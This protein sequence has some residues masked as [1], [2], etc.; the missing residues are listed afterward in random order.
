ML[1]NLFV[2]QTV[3]AIAEALTSL[4]V[5]AGAGRIAVIGPSRVCR[6]LAE[7]GHAVM[8]VVDVGDADSSTLAGVVGFGVGNRD[9]W[10]TLLTAWTG[11]I[12]DG[13]AVVLV[14]RAP[15]TELSRRALCAGLTELQQR[16][17]GRNWI[18]S[19]LVTHVG[20]RALP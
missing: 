2:G 17:V 4:G 9:D 15:A 5:R 1:S 19:G 6:A 11:R 14:D 16:R 13:G 10:A 3:A 7:R 20:E 8:P 12:S 18:T